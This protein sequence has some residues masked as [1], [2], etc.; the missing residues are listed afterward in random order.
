MRLQPPSH[1]AFYGTLMSCF[2]TLEEL[3]VRH[4]LR[5]VG[6]CA[7]GGRLFDLGDW[8]TLQ[9]GGGVVAGEVF[10]VLDES[11]FAKLDPFEDY[12]PLAPLR[13]SYMRSAVWLLRPQLRAWLY[14]TNVPVAPEREIPGGSWTQWLTARAAGEPRDLPRAAPAWR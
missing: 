10:E 9:P 8:P 4:L 11:V 7:I 14:V 1:I 3:D 6:P 13:S 5:L 2:D 12:D